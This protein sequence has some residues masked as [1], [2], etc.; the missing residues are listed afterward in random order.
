MTGKYGNLARPKSPS[1]ISVLE[2]NALE[3]TKVNKLV[4]TE[5]PLLHIIEPDTW[6]NIPIPIVEGFKAQ[7]KVLHESEVQNF[8]FV[9]KTNER[10]FKLQKQFDDRKAKGEIA[11]RAFQKEIENKIDN[12]RYK[13]DREI[14][15]HDQQLKRI[16]LH[17]EQTSNLLNSTI[18]KHDDQ[19]EM[20]EM[21]IQMLTTKL[22][23]SESVMR[24]LM[25][26]LE[27]TVDERTRVCVGE[28]ELPPEEEQEATTP[29]SQKSQ[30]SHKP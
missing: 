20:L 13:T 6:K 18:A 19:I 26:D 4:K 30:G 7:T 28:I 3:I 23:Q 5:H 14:R 24:G 8:N 29:K 17:N 15:D 2:P 11:E 10:L 25:K 9:I 21:K 27:N 22:D 1:A 12:L 16:V